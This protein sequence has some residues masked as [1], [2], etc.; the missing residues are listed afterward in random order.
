MDGQPPKHPEI[1]IVV[2]A[3]NEEKRLGK[4][5]KTLVDYCKENFDIYEIIVVDD[6]SKDKTSDVAAQFS[7]QNVRI[8]RNE[9]NRGKGYSVKRG[10]LEARYNPVLFSDSDLAT[11][12]EEVEKM[13]PWLDKGYAVV[14]ASRN[15][16][17]SNLVVKQPFYRQFLGR[18][19]PLLVNLLAV[20]G[21]KDT[22][23]G[24]KL[25]NTEAAKRIVKYQTFERFAFDVELLF[26]A[27]K[28]GHRIKEVGVTW[29]DQAGSKVS[30]I[31]D[32]ISMGKDVLKLRWNHLMGRYRIKAP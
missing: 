31:K 8:L 11:P 1:S 21:I 16:K 12:I 3:Y 20:R 17:T 28:M 22:Q 7:R 10:I 19:F 9:P 24:F 5:L 29:I 27:R 13:L 30:P 2:P 6:G 15:M 26:I 18:S 23:C 32:S 25:F 14:I 4:S